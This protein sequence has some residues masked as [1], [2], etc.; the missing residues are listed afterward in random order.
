MGR[1][2]QKPV[3]SL[4]VFHLVTKVEEENRIRPETLISQGK[5]AEMGKIRSESVFDNIVNGGTLAPRRTDKELSTKI[6]PIFRHL[7]ADCGGRDLDAL[8][9]PDPD[10]RQERLA[11][12][13]WWDL[14]PED[15][16]SRWQPQN[17]T[18]PILD[19]LTVRRR[20]EKPDV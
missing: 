20:E 5:M 9:D 14:D 3:V 18:V 1:K 17:T 6:T 4:A 16:P 12:R 10:Q 7:S 11:V 13:T 15:I 2:D 19:P 8:R